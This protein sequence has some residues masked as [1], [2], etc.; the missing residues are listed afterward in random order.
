MLWLVKNKNYLLFDAIGLRVCVTL[1]NRLKTKTDNWNSKICQVKKFSESSETIINWTKIDNI[2]NDVVIQ[3][4]FFQGQKFGEIK[5]CWIFEI[6][7]DF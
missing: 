4:I 6:C 3:I 1:N 2:L 7:K 5:N